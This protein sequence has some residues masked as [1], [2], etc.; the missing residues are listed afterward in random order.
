MKP[1]HHFALL[2]WAA[3]MAAAMSAHC[4]QTPE[5][6]AAADPATVLRL[7]SGSAPVFALQRE[8]STRPR[9]TLVILPDWGVP[10]SASP[11]ARTLAEGLAG[12]GWTTLTLFW[13]AA[14][15]PT[16]ESALNQAREALE[17][18]LAHLT[19]QGVN[20][21]LVLGHG[22]GG[23]AAADYFA[24][25]ATTRAQGLILVN[26]SLPAGRVSSRYTP[27]TLARITLPMLDIFGAADRR[28]AA[29]A[30][31]R[32]AA[33]RQDAEADTRGT[34]M[35]QAAGADASTHIPPGET[36]GRTAYRQVRVPG[37]DRDFT[38]LGAVLLKRVRGWLAK[39]TRRR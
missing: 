9:G 25:V 16:L 18:T 11:V 6:V 32:A 23:V 4:A 10:A 35:P 21:V 3:A 2:L 24:T 8:A 38:G 37:A 12:Q 36:Q 14:G 7:G 26:A 13:P 34:N 22:A 28:T 31:A 1:P 27:A 15:T 33:A 20:K 17:T 29:E 30:G 39:Q 19:G 5:W